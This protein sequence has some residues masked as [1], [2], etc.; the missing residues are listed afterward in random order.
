MEN[1]H[2]QWEYPLFLWPFSIA[3]LVHQRVPKTF[4]F[5]SPIQVVPCSY[6]TSHP[7]AE[8]YLSAML[9]ICLRP[10][11]RSRPG[12]GQLHQKRWMVSDGF[13]GDEGLID[14]WWLFKTPWKNKKKCSKPP[15]R[16]SLS[17]KTSYES[18][19]ICSVIRFV[20]KFPNR[21]E[22]MSHANDT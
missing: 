8:E 14:G 9:A 12:R 5:P 21:I 6:T 17:R 1:H 10:R 19:P 22:E 18:S 20:R 11:L 16:W 15:T 2:V 7:A 3:I 4:F 13:H